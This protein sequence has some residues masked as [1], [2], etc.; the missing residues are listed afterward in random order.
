MSG[1]S[2]KTIMQELLA[3]KLK[4]GR[5]NSIGLGDLAPNPPLNGIG[6]GLL[7]AVEA[8]KK[9]PRAYP[10]FE[11]YVD[12]ALEWRW[13]YL[14][15]NYKTIADSG[16]GYNNYEDAVHGMN[17]MRECTTAPYYIGQD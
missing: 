14:A 15:S 17:L 8:P 12:K 6:L 7:A 11:V 2:S 16:E 10:C 13:R 3:G 9:D 4:N 5:L 1:S